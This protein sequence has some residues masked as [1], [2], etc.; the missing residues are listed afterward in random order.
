MKKAA[1]QDSNG[2]SH[3]KSK[4][5]FLFVFE[6]PGVVDKSIQ[7]LVNE[8]HS[9]GKFAA[10]AHIAVFIVTKEDVFSSII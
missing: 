2:A 5:V 3:L 10:G 8:I 6:N 9:G 4:F 7:I 1:E